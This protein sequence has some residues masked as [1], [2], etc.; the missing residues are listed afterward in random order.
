VLLAPFCLVLWSLFGVKL[1]TMYYI[2]CESE[3]IF[4]EEEVPNFCKPDKVRERLYI[5]GAEGAA[6][7]LALK[8]EGITHILNLTGSAAPYPQV[9]R[10]N[11]QVYVVLNG[12]RWSWHA[13]RCS[14][15]RCP[16]YIC[17]HTI[18]SDLH[19][20]VRTHTDAL[21]CSCAGF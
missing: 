15:A 18:H 2:C 19:L 6:N 4:E 7:R 20:L 21:L 17:V 10:T 12:S 11:K 14:N 16:P 1:A 13:Q 5:S 8:K 9:L 3:E